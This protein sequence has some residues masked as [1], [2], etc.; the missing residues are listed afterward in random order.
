MNGPFDEVIPDPGDEWKRNA[1]CRSAPA[2]WFYVEDG[3]D[4]SALRGWAICGPCPVKEQCLATALRDQERFGLFG[5]M[6]AQQREILL[7]G[8]DRSLIRWTDVAA[9]L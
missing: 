9:M 3:G 4:E 7:A 2:E 6:S 8:F 1:P 5:D